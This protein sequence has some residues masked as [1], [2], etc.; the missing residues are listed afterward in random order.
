[1]SKWMEIRNDFVVDEENK[2]YIDAWKT[3][4]G[5]EAGTVIAKIDIGTHNVEYFD[6]DAR[7][8]CFAQ[9]IIKETIEYIKRGYYDEIKPSLDSLIDN[10]TPKQTNTATK[11]N[12]YSR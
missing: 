7:T 8:D 4:D 5:N 10:A 11:V 6:D 3:F 1:M 12:E 9:E 2:V